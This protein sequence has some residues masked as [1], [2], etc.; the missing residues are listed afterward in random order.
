MFHQGIQPLVVVVGIVM[1]QDQFFYTGLYGQPHRIVH[2]AVAPANMRLIFRAT[3]L[4]VEYEH[5]RTANEFQHIPVI[6]GVSR[7]GVRKKRYE[8]RRGKQPVTDGESGMVGALGTYQR[9][10]DGKV[11]F[12]QFLD[13][14]IAGQM[15]ERH[16]KISAFHLASERGDQT[17]A[18]TIAAQN[19]QSAARLI[20]RRKK[21]QAL[22]VIPVRVRNEQG[23]IERLA[24]ELL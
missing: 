8:A 22:N 11:K 18:R 20:N 10:A 6:P 15:G 4:G 19:A 13:F 21:W 1:K 14:D 23:Q 24:F 2:A 5:V 3:I 7:F 17:F 16:W 12:L 9:V